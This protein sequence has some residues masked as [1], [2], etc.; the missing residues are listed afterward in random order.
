MENRH[1]TYQRQSMGLVFFLFVLVL[2]TL[3][4]RLFYLMIGKADYYGVQ[5]KELHE[6]ERKIKA[7]RG[8]IKDCHG[9]VLAANRSVSTIS[10][11]H[12][13]MKEPE[14][15]I[16][17]LS[18]ELMLDEKEVRKKVEKVSLREKIKSNV[19]KETS[20]R[21]RNYKLAGVTVDEDY[22]REYRYDS[23]ASKVLG[24][25]GG[26]NQGIIG[27]EVSYEKYLKGLDGSILT[28]TT[29]YGTEIE[30]GAEDRIEPVAGWTLNTSLDL[31]VMEYTDQ[32]ANYLLKKKQ[33]K[34]V[35]IIVMN[36]QN[37]EIYAMASAPEFNL[38]DPY[39]IPG[40]LNKMSAKE[41]SEKRNV[42]WRNPCVSDTY[43]P[44]STFKILTTA[45]ALE[46]GVVKMTDRFHCPGY[47]IVEDRRIRCHKKGGH[48]SET[49]LDGIMNSCN[50]VFIEVGARV[51]V[52]D[53]FRKMSD[54]GLMNRTGIDVPGE[55]ST[56][57][58]KEKNVGAVE[59]A[60]MS[61]GQS[62][63]LSPIRLVS[64]AGSM[65]NGGYS[66]T[67]HFGVSA[68]SAD[69]SLMKHF[70]YGKKERV[71]SKETSDLIRMALGKVVSEGTGHKA[72]VKG[73]SVGAKTGTSEKLPRGNGKYIASTIGFAPVENPK[74]IAL[75]R[76]DEPQGLYYGGTVAAPAIAA[77]F[78][79]ILPYLCKN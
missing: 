58:H 21:I 54:F 49:F 31:P 79:N 33:A 11:I 28:M 42:M 30:N 63:Q 14:R 13:Q 5:A 22:K 26:D 76:I 64:I 53:F 18:K 43:E 20:D 75:V 78:E 55:A 51:G 44:G 24:F 67:P 23:L 72:S 45:A 9:N 27:L 73:F 60:T 12:S 4:G 8:E 65:I 15:V 46:K 25:T 7:E 40:D 6:R 29:A 69:G 3:L 38:N 47:K 61:F 48:G 74:V 1:R 56:I 57:I 36:P 71:V 37:G 59:L 66:I 32:L 52:S 35:D 77:L 70:S 39:R 10:V 2:L 17:L 50:P 34:S 62:F 68:V 16:T 19:D 41:K